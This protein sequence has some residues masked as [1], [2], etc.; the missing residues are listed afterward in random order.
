MKDQKFGI[1]IEVTGITRKMAA[2]VV[3]N[4]FG[5]PFCYVGSSYD[6]WEIQD[7]D[8]RTW[9][10]VYDGSI[11]PQKNRGS[12]NSDNYKVELVSPIC[13]YED[14]ETIQELVR[15]LRQRGALVN[16]SCGV[17][18]HIDATNHTAQT[19]RNITNIMASKEDLIFKTLQVD[20]NRET[21]FCKK[22]N[23]RFLQQINSRR[24]RSK[25]EIQGI[26]YQGRDQSG[27]H[28][29]N[30]RYHALNLHSTWNKG[31]IEFRLFNGS[32]HAGEIKTYI[33]FSLAISHQAMNQ[34]FACHS[35]TTSTNEKYTF[36]TWLLRLGMIGDEFKTARG[37][38]LKNLDGCIAWKNPEDAIK[39]RE[40]IK[41]KKLEKEEINQTDESEKDLSVSM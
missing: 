13:K 6:A 29:D 17:H 34:R 2:E 36:R 24:P 39:Q 35:K 26:W 11:T 23:E 37:H 25:A 10:I 16:T 1:E 32:L 21:R 27:Y 9:K 18:V 22:V 14:I 38:L 20:R 5:K 8:N 19:I 4:Y 12:E 40:E 28:Y 33:Q 30:S 15:K 3:A 7:N 31:T 41:R